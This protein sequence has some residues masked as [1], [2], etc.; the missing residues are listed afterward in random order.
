[1]EFPMLF[2]DPIQSLFLSNPLYDEVN[3]KVDHGFY[4]PSR[5]T[6]KHCQALL[7]PVSWRWASKPFTWQS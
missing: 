5:M 1:M 2:T 3:S 7:E 4:L 6:N